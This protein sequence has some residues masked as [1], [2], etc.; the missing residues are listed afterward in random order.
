MVPVNAAYQEA[1]SGA[2]AD[3]KWTLMERI[4]KLDG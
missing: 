4:Y 3:E 2:A 1:S